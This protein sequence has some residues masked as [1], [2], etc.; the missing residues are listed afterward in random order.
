MTLSDPV[1]AV[2]RFNRFYTKHVGALDEGLLQSAL[3]LPEARLVYELA[4]R[5][6]P[7]A[8]Y[9][10]RELG[11]DPG[12]LSRL[13]KSLETRG[14]LSRSASDVDARQQH[15]T[16]TAKGQAQ[17]RTLDARSR[18]QVNAMLDALDPDGRKRLLAAMTTIE[19]LLGPAEDPTEPY[20]IR[21]HQPGDIGWV[22]HRHGV[23]YTREYGW[24]D[25]FEAFV[26]EIGAEF[27]RK[28]DAKRDRCW[29]AERDG[30]VVGSV[31]LVK[32]SARV[33]KLRMLYVEPSA[34]GLG[35]GKRL[36]RE[37]LR[38]A[39]QVGYRKVT[40]WTNDIL[41]AARR[42]YE[43]EGFVKVAE[44]RHHSFGKDLVGENW[45]LA[46]R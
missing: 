17:F 33:A 9:L 3:P 15:L 2:R 42:I 28:F 4:Q 25:T 44:E 5:E 14:L 41:V 46:L 38:F 27:L 21:P 23:L 11:M 16:L 36:V 12:Y 30:E 20:V 22:I 32:Q 24:D 26:A 31:F 34:R 13:L 39:R 10:A 29:I 7:T 18:D 43:A 6:A 1:S 45:E 19:R 8:T 37:C 35:I 40:L